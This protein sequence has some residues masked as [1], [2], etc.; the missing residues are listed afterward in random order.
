LARAP[1]LCEK[2]SFLEPQPPVAGAAI[3]D[4]ARAARPVLPVFSDDRMRQLLVV[5]CGM[6]QQEKPSEEGHPFR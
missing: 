3:P 5:S 2:K 4:T 6:L 1:F